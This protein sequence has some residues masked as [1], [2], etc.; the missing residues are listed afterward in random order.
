MNALRHPVVLIAALIVLGACS[1]ARAQTAPDTRGYVGFKGGVNHEQAEDGLVGTSGAGG[2]AAAI[3]FGRDW[4]GEVELWLPAYFRDSA[5]NPEHR[6]IPL[7]VS[8]I[9]SFRAGRSTPYVVAGISAARTETFLTTC[10]ADRIPP[11]P[12][13]ITQP[14]PTV[15]ACSE[16]DI[17]ERH[18]ERFNTSSGYLVLG[19]GVG[20]PLGHRLRLAPEVRVHLAATSVIVRPAV[21]FIVLF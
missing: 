20:V 18:R 13:G 5:G 10:I 1:I 19:S 4:F 16:P 6:D 11:P 7:S 2:I 12:L 8:V 15:V 14:V 17:R 9:H 3:A 21:G